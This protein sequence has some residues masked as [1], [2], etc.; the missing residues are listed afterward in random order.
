M[1]SVES[2]TSTH[3]SEFKRVFFHHDRRSQHGGER[4]RMIPYDTTWYDNEKE[5]CE[6]SSEFKPVFMHNDTPF[7][8][9]RTKIRPYASTWN[10]DDVVS[11]TNMLNVVTV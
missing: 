6:S 1:S 5:Q 8:H 10:E 2:N 11:Y 3:I 4:F 7:D 9:V